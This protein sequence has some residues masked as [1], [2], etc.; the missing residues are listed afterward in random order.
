MFVCFV[1]NL[2][3]PELKTFDCIRNAL[4]FKGDFADFKETELI[5]Y[6]DF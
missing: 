4:A 6:S 3:D 2:Q 1:F 5:H